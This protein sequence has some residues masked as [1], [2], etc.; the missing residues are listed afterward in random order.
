MVSLKSSY[1]VEFKIENIFFNIAFFE[2]LS[3]IKILCEHGIF[4][5]IF[6]TFT[7]IILLL[8]QFFFYFLWLFLCYWLH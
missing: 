6:F 7:V 5:M 8:S 3:K 4:G 1:S 2:E